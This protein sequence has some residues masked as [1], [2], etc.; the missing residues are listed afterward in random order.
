M[1]GG[2]VTDSAR[3]FVVVELRTHGV[4]GTPP[5]SML[6]TDSVV[7]VD[8]DEYKRFFQ[9]S[10][11]GNPKVADP[12]QHPVMIDGTEHRRLREAYHWGGMTSGGFMQALW[13]LLLP[14][15]LVNLA[16]W[17][18]P[19]PTGP[20]TARVVTTAR[21][22]IRAIGL[23]LTALITAQLTV[24]LADLFFAQCLSEPSRV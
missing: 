13:A 8:N 5:E 22:L 14:F 9:E 18:L 20:R 19:A 12:F 24:I 4:S 21:A 15:S 17:M 10:S 7:A 23:L 3:E 1:S 16:Q 2:E 11:G 6:E